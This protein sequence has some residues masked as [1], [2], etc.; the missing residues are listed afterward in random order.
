[1]PTYDYSCPTNG[2][3]VEVSH[4]MSEDLVTWGDVCQRNGLELGDTPADSPVVRLATGGNIITSSHS[5]KHFEPP[6]CASGGC[7]AG[8][9]CGI[10]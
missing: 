10:G 8:G 1:M 9:M 2:K 7:C 5:G 6:A 3:V 4:R